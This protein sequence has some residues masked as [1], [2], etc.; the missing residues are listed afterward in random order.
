MGGVLYANSIVD[1]LDGRPYVDYVAHIHLFTSE[2]GRTF[3]RV[4]PLVD[5]GYFVTTSRPDQVLVAARQ[6]EIDLISE[7]GYQD[8]SFVGINYMKIQLDFV[9][10]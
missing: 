2:D 8:E 10:D 3:E 9:V 6:H 5:E 4:V 1:F 7:I